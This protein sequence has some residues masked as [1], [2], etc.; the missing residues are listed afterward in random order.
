MRRILD[1]DFHPP[2][3]LR[4]FTFQ[5][6]SV[7]RFDESAL[8]GQVDHRGTLLR[9]Y[10]FADRWFKIN[11]TTDVAGNFVE[12]QPDSTSIPFCFNCDIATPM[13]KQGN[14]VFAV[15]LLIDVLVRAD[16]ST[17]QIVDEDEFAAAHE[18]GWLSA[19]EVQGAQRGLADLI[20]LIERKQLVQFLVDLSPFGSRR[21]S[22]A[23][24][25]QRVSVADFPIVQ[26]GVRPTW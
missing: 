9:H 12:E 15:D 26:P 24:D 3:D 19:P 20:E 8:I 18:H 16:G 4:L 5:P 2:N 14:A 11:V 13:L 21:A 17:Y 23:L 6:A 22:R 7:W 25:T 1:Y 10:A